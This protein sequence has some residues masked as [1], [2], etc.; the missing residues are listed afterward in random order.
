MRLNA[1]K[2]SCVSPVE[3]SLCPRMSLRK[4]FMRDTSFL[5][6]TPISFLPGFV[7]VIA[8]VVVGLVVV[9]VMA[10]ILVVVGVFL[11]ILLLML[12]LNLFMLFKPWATNFSLISLNSESTG[13]RRL[14]SFVDENKGIRVRRIRSFMVLNNSQLRNIKHQLKFIE[15]CPI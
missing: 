11:S 15:I 9:V 5:D 13:G 4:E 1:G 8:F 3:S 7:V 14:R 2:P 12:I 6:S 10:G